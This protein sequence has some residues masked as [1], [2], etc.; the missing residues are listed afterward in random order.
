MGVL[1]ANGSAEGGQWKVTA[2]DWIVIPLALSAGR[3]SV[4]VDPSSTSNRSVKTPFQ[5]V[6]N[7]ECR[8]NQYCD[9]HKM[10]NEI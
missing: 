3:K 6:G 2:A 5:I 7:I 9:F 8:K 10:R 4:T 1:D